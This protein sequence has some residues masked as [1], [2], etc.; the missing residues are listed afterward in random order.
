MRREP[1]HATVCVSDADTHF[2]APV[3]ASTPLAFSHSRIDAVEGPGHEGV[4]VDQ[5]SLER[6]HAMVRI[7][8]PAA[9]GVENLRLASA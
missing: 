4:H 3:P 9:V 8:G 2:D 5:P 1:R 7:P 6:V